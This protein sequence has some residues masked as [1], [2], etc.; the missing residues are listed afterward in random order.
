MVARPVTFD[1][2]ANDAAVTFGVILFDILRLFVATEF[3]TTAI[4]FYSFVYRSRLKE[5]EKKRMN[6]EQFFFVVVF[7]FVMRKRKKANQFKT[8]NKRKIYEN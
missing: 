7:V 4:L 8:K 2:V 6:F 3:P 5:M 1:M